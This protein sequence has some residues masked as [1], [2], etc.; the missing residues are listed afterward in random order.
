MTVKRNRWLVISVLVV[1]VGAFLAISL[2]P[3]LTGSGGYRNNSTAP[4]GQAPAPSTAQEELEAR[5]RGYALVL[6]R[7]PDNQT[8]IQGLVDARIQLGDL[9][10]VVEPLTKLADLNP[11]IPDY[12]ILLGQT[13]QA[14]GNLDAAA[15]AYRTVLTEQPGS[16]NALQGLVAL[17]IQQ[18]RP[19]AAV[20][21]LE[22]TLQT[23]AQVNEITPGTIDEVSTQLLLAQVY[24]EQADTDA[25]LRIYDEVIPQAG[26]DFRPVLAKAMILQ[27]TDRAEAA[28]PL[29]EQAEAMAPDQF[30]D[31]VRQMIAGATGPAAGLPATGDGSSIPAADE[32]PSP[33]SVDDSEV[34]DSDPVNSPTD[35][36]DGG[37]PDEENDAFTE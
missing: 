9:E 36:P 6:E 34:T 16:L 32:V 30:K 11:D 5:A 35:A 14:L 7:E 29:F 15:E 20:A 24:I 33:E 25:A 17:L 18:N 3:L 22:D 23:A 10:G 28:A 12:Q 27:E 31:R 8:A 37:S 4:T 21:L 19:Q 1:A 26:E 13:H 2:L